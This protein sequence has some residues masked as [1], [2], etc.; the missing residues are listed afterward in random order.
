MFFKS[1]FKKIG[2]RKTTNIIQ[3]SLK[4]AIL[5]SLIVVCQLIHGDEKKKNERSLNHVVMI[6]GDWQNWPNFICTSLQLRKDILFFSC[7]SY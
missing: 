7:Q 4:S 1:A 3:V 6:K 2:F 5:T